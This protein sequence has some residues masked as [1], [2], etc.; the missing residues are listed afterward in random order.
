MIEPYYETKL[1]KLYHGD[2][3]S[4]MKKM[5]S[6]SVDLVV[7]SPPYNMRNRVRNG[8]YTERE[9]GEHLCRKYNVFDDALDINDYYTL[10][11]NVIKEMLRVSN[12]NA[13]N[14]QIVTGSKEALFQII[15]DY[16]RNLKDIII[17]DKGW[18]QPA[19]AERVLN[20]SYELILILESDAKVGRQI[21]NAFFDR[22]TE[23]NILRIGG[24]KRI[25]DTNIH[26]AIFP[27]ELPTKLI[28]MF[29]PDDAV[30]LDPFMGMGSTAVAA[31][32]LKRKWIGCE[33]SKEYCD[34]SINRLKE[35]RREILTFGE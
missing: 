15:G 16:K 24:N 29:S 11:K 33:V 23:P 14:I 30:I 21:T 2:C 8:Q 32:K 12:I 10:H 9:K 27:I 4:I 35:V 1:G 25:K 28:Q 3:L 5:E 20:A 26:G 19:I 31:E 13:Y 17:W 18:G 22:G 6:N 34:L 7:T